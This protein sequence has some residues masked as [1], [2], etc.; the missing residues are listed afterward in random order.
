[1]D[2]GQCFRFEP[3]LNNS[4]FALDIESF[5]E[6]DVRALLEFEEETSIPFSS[7]GIECPAHSLVDQRNKLDQPLHLSYWPPRKAITPSLQIQTVIVEVASRK[8]LSEIRHK[9]FLADLDQ[10]WRS[11]KGDGCSFLEAGTFVGP[12]IPLD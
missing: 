10:R 12:L 7:L 11:R 6:C 4:P 3:D 2:L 8:N 1:M 9:F 5:V